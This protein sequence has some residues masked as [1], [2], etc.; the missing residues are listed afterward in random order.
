MVAEK[1]HFKRM[2]NL[3]FANFYFSCAQAQGTSFMDESKNNSNRCDAEPKAKLT[4]L[5]F[6]VRF[7]LKKKNIFLCASLVQREYQIS[8]F[9]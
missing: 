5:L 2:H 6:F 1:K 7:E 9:W 3:Q 8:T 4:Y